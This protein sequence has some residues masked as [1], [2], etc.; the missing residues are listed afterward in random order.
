MFDLSYLP[1]VN[2]SLNGLATVLLLI[3]FYFVKTGRPILHGRMMLATFVVS[4]VFLMS[5]LT[6]HFNHPTTRFGGEGWIRPTYF[7]ILITHIILAAVVP[8][9]A[10]IA[11][12][13]ALKD[14]IEKHRR[15]TRI[16]FP[17][18][19]YVSVTGVLIYVMLRP[20]Y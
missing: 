10:V 3:G 20:Y 1:A 4:I 17:I 14:Q 13:R 16:L 18:W 15:L 2:A 6:Y 8:F 11:V 9:M 5:Y 12:W 19:V 7:F